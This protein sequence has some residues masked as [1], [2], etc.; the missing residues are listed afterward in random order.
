VLVRAFLATEDARWRRD[1]RAAIRPLLARRRTDLVTPTECG[2]V[3]EEAPCDPPSQI[4]NGWIYALWGLRDV[5]LALGDDDAGD[6]WLE[7][8]RCLG[9]VVG[10]YDVGWWTR[11]SLYPHR[12]ADLAKPFYHRL[13]ATQAEVM[14][15]LTGIDAFGQTA[16]RWRAYDNRPH[17]ALALA[18]K[19]VFRSLGR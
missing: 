19:V 5:H 7:S 15:R 11:Y 9:A 16:S 3:L 2:P 13:H 6:R 8:A 10:R 18:Q 12:L 1:A 4:L 14:F 17:C